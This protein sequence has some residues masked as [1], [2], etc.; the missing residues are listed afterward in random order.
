MGEEKKGRDIPSEAEKG[1]GTLEIIHAARP[2]A[3][4]LQSHVRKGESFP[5]LLVEEG[6]KTKTKKTPRRGRFPERPPTPRSPGG[7]PFSPVPSDLPSS[8]ESSCE[9][10]RIKQSRALLSPPTPG[11]GF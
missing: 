5:P 10:R 7:P 3:E 4:L 6:K 8:A 1:V 9:R 2:D 11:A